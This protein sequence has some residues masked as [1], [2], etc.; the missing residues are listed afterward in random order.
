MFSKQK[1][2][3]FSSLKSFLVFSLLKMPVDFGLNVPFNG[4]QKIFYWSIVVSSLRWKRLS[5]GAIT[6]LQA[7][8]LHV[9]VRRMT[10][11]TDN[12]GFPIAMSVF[13]DKN[14]C[15]TFA[16]LILVFTNYIEHPQPYHISSYKH[17]VS[18]EHCTISQHRNKHHPLIIV[19][20]LQMQ[21]LWETW[22]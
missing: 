19:S 15:V 5:T 12:Q 13:Q 6:W 10:I 4:G 8:I 2:C 18:N 14:I 7:L 20:H 9:T 3:V 21:L 1:L 17:Q 22:P 11:Y 16:L